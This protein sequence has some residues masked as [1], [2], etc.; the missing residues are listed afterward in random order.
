MFT[1]NSMQNG[2]KAGR[3]LPLWSQLKKKINFQESDAR[4]FL[5]GFGGIFGG[6]VEIN[7]E[8]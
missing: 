4:H 6:K 3:T 2:H 8:K 7:M 5:K 1:S